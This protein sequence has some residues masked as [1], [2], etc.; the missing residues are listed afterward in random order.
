MTGSNNSSNKELNKLNVNNK[1]IKTPVMNRGKGKPLTIAE[2]KAKAAAKEAEI[3]KQAELKKQQEETQRL[4]LIE[5]EKEKKKKEQEKEEQIKIQQEADKMKRSVLKMN[6]KPTKKEVV[7]DKQ[8]KEVIKDFKSPICCILGHVDTG[9]TKLLDKL[10]ESNVQ[11]LEAGGITQQIGATFFPVDMLMKKCNIDLP[12]LPGI[13]IIDTPGHESFSNLRSRGSSLC[14]LAILV[15]DI[16]H[17]LEP[18]TIESIKLL[19][20]RKTPFIV[21]LNKLDRIYEWKSNEYGNFSYD[22]QDYATQHDFDDQLLRVKG[23]MAQLGINTKL[24]NEN[25]QPKKFIS[26]VPT[27]AITGEGIPDLV[28]LFLELSYKFMLEKMRIKEE[29]ECTVLEVKNVEGFGVT[30]DCILSNGKLN[31]GDKVA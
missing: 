11:G 6:I 16:V 22:K 27:S 28:K 19:R 29:T 24:F 10:R 4:R 12:D 21:A 2:I 23:E 15:V 26:L 8:V 18:Q 17:G 20:Q 7:K 9:K 30:L 13:L 1:V 31:E 3:K 14:N 5:I 25:D